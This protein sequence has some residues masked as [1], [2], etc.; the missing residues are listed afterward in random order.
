MTSSSLLY[1]IMVKSLDLH[2]RKWKCSDV[3]FNSYLLPRAMI[4]YEDIYVFRS[5]IS[6]KLCFLFY[7]SHLEVPDNAAGIIM[8]SW[9]EW[10][11]RQGGKHTGAPAQPEHQDDTTEVQKTFFKGHN[12]T[13][14]QT[15]K[16]FSS[17]IKSCSLKNEFFNLFQAPFMVNRRN[18]KTTVA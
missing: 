10:R 11:S 15:I 13:F 14:S 16:H 1:S 5:F 3:I 4:P 12:M 7:Q 18:S 6:R 2:Y 9:G 8:R 17:T